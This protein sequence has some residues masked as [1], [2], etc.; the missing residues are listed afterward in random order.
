MMR[1]AMKRLIP[2]ALLSLLA[3]AAIPASAET[4]V[5]VDEVPCL[6]VGENSPVHVRVEGDLAGSDVR[7]YFRRLHDVVEDF[8]WVRLHPQGE[9]HY[10]G[11]IPQP[12]DDELKKRELERMV[13]D[14]DLLT[15]RLRED[16]DSEF[17]K[18]RRA[19]WWR[20][21]ERTKHRNP[22]GDLDQDRIEERANY[23]RQEQRHWM[24]KLT[25]RELEE[26]LRELEYEPAEYFAA[27]YDARGQEVA[28]SDVDVTRVEDRCDNEVKG[29]EEG[30][31]E[32]LTVG[33]T[34]S[35]QIGEEVFH[36]KCE[37]VITRINARGEFRGDDVCRACVIAWWHK[38]SFLIPTSAVATAT[39]VSVIESEGPRRASPSRP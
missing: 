26:F 12:T 25:N 17:D 29:Q 20:Y 8:Y 7:F 9:G 2:V 21:K 18:Y 24:D 27:V 38:Q 30:L 15:P 5:S 1:E 23:G 11:V 34:A 32:N 39:G 6:E 16:N 36:W 28:A 33:E 37:G 3:A 14:R 13:E 22:N 10:W 35:W 4:T 19:L 31:A